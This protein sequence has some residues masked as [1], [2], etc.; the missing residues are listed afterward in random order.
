ML[1]DIWCYDISYIS[2]ITY[3]NYSDIN[4]KL[5]KLQKKKLTN[6]EI[7]QKAHLD[8]PNEFKQQYVDILYKHQKTISI[9]KYN[10]GLAK[11]YKP[12]IH[13]KDN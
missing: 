3:D 2:N 8:V 6:K 1:R 5:P 4:T 9:N 12:K 7:L 10:L 11:S 13:L